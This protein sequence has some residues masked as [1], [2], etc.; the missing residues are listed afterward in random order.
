MQIKCAEIWIAS[1]THIYW[2]IIL[3]RSAQHQTFAPEYTA[4]EFFPVI[5][6]FNVSRYSRENCLLSQ[7]RQIQDTHLEL[8]I[9]QWCDS[10][11]QKC[12][13]GVCMVVYMQ[14]SVSESVHM[15]MCAY[16]SQGTALA[17]FLRHHPCFGLC[18]VLFLFLLLSLVSWVFCLFVPFCFVFLCCLFLDRIFHFSRNGRIA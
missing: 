12:R 14:V 16:G 2:Q 17:P 4:R 11:C 5:F 13:M 18:F 1:S 10:Y 15:H 7:P 9:V 3:L 6:V 8:Q